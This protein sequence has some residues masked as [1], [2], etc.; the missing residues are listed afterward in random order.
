MQ[1]LF[2]GVI[3]ISK[4]F[5][6]VTLPAHIERYLSTSCLKAVIGGE[7]QVLYILERNL[8]TC[9]FKI[10]FGDCLPSA[11]R[12]CFNEISIR[13]SLAF[14]YPQLL[15]KAAYYEMTKTPG[16]VVADI[17]SKIVFVEF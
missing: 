6:L 11:S 3:G 1:T 17:R 10:I 5:T 7:L 8:W 12:Q 9:T 16:C 13:I 2:L 4:L 15:I 14:Y